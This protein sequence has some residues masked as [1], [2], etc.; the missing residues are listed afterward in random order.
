MERKGTRKASPLPYDPAL[1]PMM[2][3]DSVDREL[4]FPISNTAMA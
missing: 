2:D 4:G 3:A 1:V